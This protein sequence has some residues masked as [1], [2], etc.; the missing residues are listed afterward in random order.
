MKSFYK[1]PHPESGKSSDFV[2]VYG[3]DGMAS[4]EFRIYCGGAVYDT[5]SIGYG[6]SYGSPEIALRDALIF[7]TGGKAFEFQEYFL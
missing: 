1:L 2:E 6:S 7:A 5:G 4:Y 3:I